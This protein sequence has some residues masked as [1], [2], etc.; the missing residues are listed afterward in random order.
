MVSWLAP[1]LPTSALV[2]Y[3]QAR[4]DFGILMVENCTRLVYFLNL[5]H[6]P[7]NFLI[8][9]QVLPIMVKAWNLLVLWLA[10]SN[11]HGPFLSFAHTFWSFRT[12]AGDIKLLTSFGLGVIK[13]LMKPQNC[14]I[15]PIVKY[16]DRKILCSQLS[17]PN[18]FCFNNLWYEYFLHIRYSP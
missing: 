13:F 12:A 10:S 3:R 1:Q 7:P 6:W 11:Y 8:G 2:F 16:H 5:Y 17:I 18:Q 15:Y 9:Y 14:C 4:S